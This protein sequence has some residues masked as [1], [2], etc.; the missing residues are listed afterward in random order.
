MENPPKSVLKNNSIGLCKQLCLKALRHR[1]FFLFPIKAD[2]QALA[3]EHIR[4]QNPVPEGN[5]V[6]ERQ[7]WP[8]RTASFMKCLE[9]IW[10]ELKLTFRRLRRANLA[11][12]H[13]APSCPLTA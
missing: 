11:G 4:L 13:F 12:V 7:R 1:G 9:V 2:A 6:R 8:Q 10:K 5:H 3:E